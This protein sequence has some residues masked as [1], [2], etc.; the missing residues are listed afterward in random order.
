VF[1]GILSAAYEG[2]SVRSNIFFWHGNCSVQ[3]S[4]KKE[5]SDMFNRILCPIDFD[6]NSL[7]ALRMARRIVEQNKARLYVLHAVSLGDPVVVSAPLIAEQKEKESHARAE[8][9]RI[10]KTELLGVNYE[11]LL[12]FGHPAK[13]IIAGEA[14]TN[15]ELVVMAT[16]GRGGFSHLILGSV[17]EKVVRES[18]CPVLTVRMTAAH[19]FAEE[20]KRPRLDG[21]S[22]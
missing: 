15:A 18:S 7:E 6:G 9:L 21:P 5:T 13:E 22:V 20:L 2:L 1:L 11:T 16:H 4:E 17:A 14:A 12:Q 3:V 8:L 19:E 10:A